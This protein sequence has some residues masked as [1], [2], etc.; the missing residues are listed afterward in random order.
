MKRNLKASLIAFSLLSVAC[1]A[2]KQ[3]DFIGNW[4][5]VMPA[6]PDITEGITLQKEGKAA[7]IGMAT[8]KYETWKTEGDRLIL[9]GKSIGNGQTFDFSDTLKVVRLTPDSLVLDKYGRYR[10]HYYKVDRLSDIKPF[11]V[12]DSL[13]K[14]EGLTEIESRVF[15]GSLPVQSCIEVKSELTVYNYKNSGDGVYKL[16]NTYLRGDGQPATGNSYGR[17]YTLKG[18]AADPN[19][20]VW[21]LVPFH[22]GNQ[23]NLL[24]KDNELFLLND[25]FEKSDNPGQGTLILSE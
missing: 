15:K 18:D 23:T 6:S 8:L 9:G 5:E 1:T 20:V 19:A 12:L 13:R 22:G 11:N 24:Y 16:T 14:A 21:Q 10:I 17:L 25:R 4:I 3:A 7:S 2:D